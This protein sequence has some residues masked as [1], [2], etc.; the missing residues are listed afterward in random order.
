MT[1]PTRL[2]PRQLEILHLF[3]D[4]QQQREVATALALSQKTVSHHS[5]E[6][7]RRLNARSI[8]HAAA[9]VARCERDR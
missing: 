8:A 7:L 9:M 2:S 4:G 5:T 3:S 6:I 1:C